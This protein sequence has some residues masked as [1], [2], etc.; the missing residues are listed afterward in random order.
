MVVSLLKAPLTLAWSEVRTEPG[1]FLPSCRHQVFTRSVRAR[2][3][4]S[5]S[6]GETRAISFPDAKPAENISQQVVGGHL[7][8]NTS[9][10]SYRIAEILGQQIG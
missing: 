2:R 5:Y 4:T 7:P 8:E 6:S 3:E 1:Y 9:K 10:F